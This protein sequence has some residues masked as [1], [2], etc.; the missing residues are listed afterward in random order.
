VIV[1]E[2]NDDLRECMVLILESAGYRVTNACDGV[3]AIAALEGMPVPP[4]VML[5][6]MKMPNMNGAEVLAW[7]SA[8]ARLSTMPVVVI[9]SDRRCVAVGARRILL[10]PTTLE[11]LLGAVKTFCGPPTRQLSLWSKPV[12]SLA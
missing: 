12:A 3:A 10:K 6:D 4:C 9:T 8:H 7:L 2:N 1:V 11:T 5:L